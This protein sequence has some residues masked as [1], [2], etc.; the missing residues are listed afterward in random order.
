MLAITSGA[1]LSD[2]LGAAIIRYVLQ[3]SKSQNSLLCAVE[4]TRVNCVTICVF[5][6]EILSKGFD[7]VPV[8]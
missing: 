8:S 4:Y 2:Q 6:L 5:V 1:D 7:I 3:S